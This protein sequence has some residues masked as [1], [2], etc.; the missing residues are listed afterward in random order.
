MRLLR[1]LRLLGPFGLLTPFCGGLL[2]GPFRLL[3]P[4]RGGLPRRRALC[5]PRRRG[6]PGRGDLA[7]AC[8]LSGGRARRGRARRRRARSG[9][10]RSGRAQRRRGRRGQARVRDG[11]ARGRRVPGQLRGRAPLPFDAGFGPEPMRTLPRGKPRPVDIRASGAWLVGTRGLE[12]RT[13]CA[14]VARL[15]R[16]QGPAGRLRRQR[17]RPG[18]VWLTRGR[19]YG[20]GARPRT[21]GRGRGRGRGRGGGCGCGCAGASSVAPGVPEPGA[22]P[23]SGEGTGSGERGA[24]RWQGWLP[25][26]SWDSPDSWAGALSWRGTDGDWLACRN[27]PAGGATP[28]QELSLA[29]GSAA[30]A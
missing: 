26:D 13:A 7:G 4:F 16:A 8:G 27:H 19:R 30:A 23:G 15:G 14:A 21:G 12:A 18:S 6:R 2:L 11:G 3:R 17:G 10:A 25:R 20:T 5:V 22:G 1:P 24:D 28:G 9:R 29:A